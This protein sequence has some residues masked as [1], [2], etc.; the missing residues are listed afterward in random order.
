[1]WRARQDTE[2]SGAT[3]VINCSSS[4]HFPFLPP[5]C[6]RPVWWEA[7]QLFTTVH[8]TVALVPICWCWGAGLGTGECLP[9]QLSHQYLHSGGFCSW[10]LEWI[11]SQ[12]SCSTSASHNPHSLPHSLG[13]YDP[14]LV[15]CVL[16]SRPM[17]YYSLG[18]RSQVTT[19]GMRT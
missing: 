9:R 17:T 3:L 13:A 11:R 6:H 7:L 2:K 12:A 16:R 18:V 4:H 1:M 19:S 8:R 5:D 15:W 14:E 10:P